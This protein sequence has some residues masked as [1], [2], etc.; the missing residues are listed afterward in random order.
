LISGRH[1]HEQNFLGGGE[2]HGF[3]G[4]VEEFLAVVLFKLGI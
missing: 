3:S 4:A 2:F 1:K